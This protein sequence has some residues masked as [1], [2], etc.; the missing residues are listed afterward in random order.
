MTEAIMET[1]SM[2]VTAINGTGG[3]IVS[4]ALDGVRRRI[5]GGT[6]G[7]AASGNGFEWVRGFLEKKQ[8]RIP[9]VDVLV[10]L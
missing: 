3:S 9:C 4:A 2:A 6:A 8:L 1:A 5:T 7:A 10:R